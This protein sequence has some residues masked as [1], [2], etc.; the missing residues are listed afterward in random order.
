MSDISLLSG[1]KKS[2]SSARTIMAWAL[3][4]VCDHF[5]PTRGNREQCANCPNPRP[6]HKWAP[7]AEVYKQVDRQLAELARRGYQVI[8]IG[9]DDG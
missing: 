2:E 1:A 5:K 9:D 3:R 4:G 7:D 6:R 8:L